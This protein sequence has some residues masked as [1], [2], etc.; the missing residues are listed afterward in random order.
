[1]RPRRLVASVRPLNFT[2]RSHGLKSIVIFGATTSVLLLTCSLSSAQPAMTGAEAVR[3]IDWNALG[4]GSPIPEQMPAAESDDPLEAG[5]ARQ[6]VDRVVTPQYPNTDPWKD[7]A[8]AIVSKHRDPDD[9]WASRAEKELWEIIQDN[10]PRGRNPRV[11][12]NS[13]GCLCYVER[14]ERVHYSIVYLELVRNRGRSL[15]L[16]RNDISAIIGY[17]RPLAAQGARD[18]LA[19]Q[20]ELTIVKRP[21]PDSARRSL[22]TRNDLPP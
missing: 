10:I 3:E 21:V 18:G 6:W 20:W 19:S 7:L 17:L 16:S 8:L 11:F 9:Q 5:F 1:M 2:V 15:G 14:E 13:F 4:P 22:G 12:C